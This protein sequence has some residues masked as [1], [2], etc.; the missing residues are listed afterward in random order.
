MFAIHSFIDSF[1]KHPLHTSTVVEMFILGECENRLTL[2]VPPQFSADFFSDDLLI[3]CLMVG[4][5]SRYWKGVPEEVS[6]I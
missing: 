3:L 1:D 5:F 6:D 4:G 2:Q